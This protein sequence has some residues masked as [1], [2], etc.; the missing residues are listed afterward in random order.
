MKRDDKQLVMNLQEKDK[1]YSMDWVTAARE[2]KEWY[3]KSVLPSPSPEYIKEIL[4]YEPETGKLFWQV[5][6]LYKNQL[7]MEERDTKLALVKEIKRY[8]LVG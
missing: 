4:H 2:T 6:K 1:H 8:T 5:K 3:T 7:V